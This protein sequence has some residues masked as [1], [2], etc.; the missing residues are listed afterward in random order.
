MLA[1][2]M[3]MNL[4]LM[5]LSQGWIFYENKDFDN[6]LDFFLSKQDHVISK[7]FIGEIYR[8]DPKLSSRRDFGLNLIVESA[9]EGFYFAWLALGNFYA[10]G[11]EFEQDLEI[12]IHWYTKGAEYGC[13]R[14]QYNLGLLYSRK[15]IYN[16]ELA[17]KWLLILSLTEHPEAQRICDLMANVCSEG[18]KDRGM[19]LA[20]HWIQETRIRFQNEP[21]SVCTDTQYLLRKYYGRVKLF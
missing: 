5:D 15:P 8:N 3:N 10:N 16:F 20:N 18:V 13:S 6:A 17:Y 14:C 21:V 11:I 9:N 12:A 7:Y 4:A 2:S 19:E 1:N